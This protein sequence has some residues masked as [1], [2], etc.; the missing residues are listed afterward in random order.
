MPKFLFLCFCRFVHFQMLSLVERP[1]WGHFLPERSSCVLLGPPHGHPLVFGVAF[2]NKKPGCKNLSKK[3]FWVV[4]VMARSVGSGHPGLAGA[5]DC[6]PRRVSISTNTVN[7]VALTA[8]M[9]FLSPLEFA[10]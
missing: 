4:Q 1:K 8:A 9:R 3:L 6:E 5:N 2:P 10:S 7:G